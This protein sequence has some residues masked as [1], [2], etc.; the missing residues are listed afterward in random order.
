MIKIPHEP[1]FYYF[2]VHKYNNFRY[3]IN[4]T[5]LNLLSLSEQQKKI[6]Y[7]G[8]VG[9]P[10]VYFSDASI[11]L[12]IFYPQQYYSEMLCLVIYYNKEQK[13]SLFS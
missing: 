7:N 10:K 2:F 6:Q 3:C 12:R 9:Y 4:P 13:Y 11:L 5:N 1:G 8:N